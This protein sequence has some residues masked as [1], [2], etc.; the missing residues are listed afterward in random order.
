MTT[1]NYSP[2]C[3]NCCQKSVVLATIPYTISI[4]HDGRKYDVY[5]PTFSVPKCTNC[6]EI[7]IDE[8]ASEQIDEA[9][10]NQ[11]RLLTGKQ[12]CESRMMLQLDQPTFA[13]LLGVGTLSVSR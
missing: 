1:R 11:A 5:M 13:G 6:G 4:E 9:F 3:A 12:I 10:R 8:I 7:S 2:R